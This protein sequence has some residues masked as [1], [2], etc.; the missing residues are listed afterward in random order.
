MWSRRPNC[1][2]QQMNF[3]NL[4]VFVKSPFCSLC[5]CRRFPL[6]W[7]KRPAKVISLSFI[8]HMFLCSSRTFLPLAHFRSWSLTFSQSLFFSLIPVTDGFVCSLLS[9][10]WAAHCRLCYRSLLVDV[11]WYWLG[12]PISFLPSSGNL[13]NGWGQLYYPIRIVLVS[14]YFNKKTDAWEDGKKTISIKFSSCFTSQGQQVYRVV[15]WWSDKLGSV[16]F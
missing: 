3:F 8:Q 13:G 10:V 6:W 1:H 9:A 15:D 14:C 4:L 5:W 11:N 2:E 16:F 7:S 12:N